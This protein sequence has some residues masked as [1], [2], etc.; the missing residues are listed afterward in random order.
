MRL[1]LIFPLL[2][3]FSCTNNKSSTTTPNLRDELRSDG[4]SIPSKGD[5]SPVALKIQPLKTKLIAIFTTS[6]GTIEVVLFPKRAPK[7]VKNF[8]QLVKNGFYT[9]TI[10]HRVIKNFMI[11]AGGYRAGTLNKIAVAGPGVKNE[12]LKGYSNKRGTLSLARTSDKDSGKAQFFI[13]LKDNFNLDADLKK[14]RAGYTVFGKVIKGMDVVDTI[15]RTPV[16]SQRPSLRNLPL[17]EIKII[18]IEIVE[19]IP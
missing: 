5:N 11:Q 3:V 18:K 7:T 1:L 16:D 9:N 17:T 19:R 15:G 12:S 14:F 13:N 6:K 10:F 2:L 4:I 8:A